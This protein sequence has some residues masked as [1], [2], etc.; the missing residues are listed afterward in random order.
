MNRTVKSGATLLSYELLRT[1][2]KNMEIRVLNRGVVRVF[3]P[4]R[5]RLRDVDDFVISRAGWIGNAMRSIDEYAKKHER[6]HPMEDGAPLLIEGKS[7][8]LRVFPS[9]RSRVVEENDLQIYTADTSPEAVRAQLKSYL[10]ERARKKIDERLAHFIPLIGRAPNRVAIRDQKTRW[11]S[12]SS[13]N[14]LNFNYKLIMAPPEAL[15]YVVIHELCHLYEFNH[16]AKFWKRVSLF[17]SDYLIWKR[18]L[19]ENGRILGV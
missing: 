9:G 3:A 4:A 18:W 11:G 17:Q 15:D 2:R 14:N 5:A 13:G 10:V 1:Q 19:K 16:S 6:E 12:C 7:V 8:R